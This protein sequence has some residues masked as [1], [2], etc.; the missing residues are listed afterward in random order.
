MFVSFQM[1]LV[2]ISRVRTITLWYYRYVISFFFFSNIFVLSYSKNKK[3]TVFIDLY[4]CFIS[5]CFR[6]FV[7]LYFSFYQINFFWN[8]RYVLYFVLDLFFFIVQEQTLLNYSI[9][10]LNIVLNL[11]LNYIKVEISLS[12][13]TPWLIH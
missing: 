4:L 12:C 11:A 3:V 5:F 8:F 1:I 6:C 7:D 13:D 10:S 2:V 9:L